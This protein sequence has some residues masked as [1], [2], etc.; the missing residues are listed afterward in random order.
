M[1]Q[2]LKKQDSWDYF[3]DSDIVGCGK[4]KEGSKLLVWDKSGTITLFNF[5]KYIDNSSKE[6]QTPV[7]SKNDSICSV[8]ITDMSIGHGYIVTVSN[9]GDLRLWTRERGAFIKKFDLNSIMQ[10]YISS[11]KVCPTGETLFIGGKDMRIY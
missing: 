1:L 9:E 3:F 5:L 8:D 10:D 2:S 11:M 4:N 7:H 6:C